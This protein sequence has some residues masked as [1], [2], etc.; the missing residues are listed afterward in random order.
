MSHFTKH[1][2]INTACFLFLFHV[3]NLVKVN[4]F[5]FMKNDQLNSVSKHLSIQFV[6]TGVVV[7]LNG[8]ERA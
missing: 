4:Q 2:R 8:P 3:S 1:I 6:H 7:L 5:Y